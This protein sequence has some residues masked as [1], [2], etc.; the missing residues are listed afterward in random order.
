MRPLDDAER[1]A[2]AAGRWEGL[3][4]SRPDPHSSAEDPLIAPRVR[5]F[6]DSGLGKTI[7]LL[8]CEE[9]I[10]A[11]GDGRVPV[12]LG[13]LIDR[14]INLS[15]ISWNR[16]RREVLRAI[17]EAAVEPGVPDDD[18][19][20]GWEWF[21]GVVARGAGV[22]LL[23]ALDQS[24]DI[25]TGLGNFFQL[26]GLT[27]SPLLV[28]GRP[29]T[30]NSRGAVWRGTEAWATLRVLPFD[31]REQTIFLGTTLAPVLVP[32][33]DDKPNPWDDDYQAELQRHRWKELLGVPLLLKFLG[34]LAATR[35][36]AGQAK[37]LTYPH[38]YAIYQAAVEALL[39]KGRA[40]FSDGTKGNAAA[41]MA[42]RVLPILAL[43]SVRRHAFSGVVA[44]PA[45]D[46]ARRKL[47][48]DE[49]PL[50]R[51]LRYDLVQLNAV[52][53]ESLL[54]GTTNRMPG[55]EFRHRSMLE[56]HA[57]CRLADLFSEESTRAEANSILEDIH[58][59][60]EADGVTF[61]RAL[62]DPGGETCRHLPREWEWTLRF[63][64]SHAP[65]GAGRDALAWRLINLGN[66]WV[67]YEG[68]D[69]DHLTIADDVAAVCRWL[70]H[71]D[72][73]RRNYRGAWSDGA[74]APVAAWVGACGRDASS[75]DA[76]PTVD[77]V[78]RGL[79]EADW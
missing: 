45:Y 64:L 52:T 47:Q 48:A 26:P 27:R 36:A 70:V 28:A 76:S 9:R 31:R 54:E 5:L 63:A 14:T 78:A 35:D 16:S 7:Q 62:L 51:D 25:L 18:S 40:S 69:Q 72:S 29:E 73:A 75:A 24:E 3:R 2:F 39:E 49:G 1:R 30:A 53:A 57:G 8:A 21:Q 44:G 15:D 12:R 6:A 42:H 79:T 43:E 58:N 55:L 56:Y 71:R 33:S 65:E 60:L 46:A 38:R 74:P 17:Y 22:F 59:V 11:A 68:L 19:A 4:K 37:L 32:K 41:A 23:D 77:E 61:R 20:A 13:K 67:V 50:D 66:P 34:D 10:A